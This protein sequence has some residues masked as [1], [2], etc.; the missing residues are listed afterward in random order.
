MELA[1]RYITQMRLTE[2]LAAK[3]PVRGSLPI[4]DHGSRV[5]EKA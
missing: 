3:V 2:K 1:G 5:A 4:R